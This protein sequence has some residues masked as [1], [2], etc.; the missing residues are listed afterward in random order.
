MKIKFSLCSMVIFSIMASSANALTIIN[1]K[2]N[3][4]VTPTGQVL[5]SL[6]VQYDKN[7]DPI[8]ISKQDFKVDG[9]II[10]A[11]Y[12]SDSD[13]NKTKSGKYITLSVDDKLSKLVFI[14]SKNF[15]VERKSPYVTIY[16]IGSVAAQTNSS[17][18]AENVVTKVDKVVT[19]VADDF[20]PM[21]FHDEKN[22]NTIKYN[23]FIPKHYDPNKKYPLVLFMHDASVLSDQVDTTLMQGTGAL[24]FA[25]P[26]AQI[27]HE[28]FVL[29]PQYNQ[30]IVNDNHDVSN[31]L[32]STINLVNQLSNEYS[33]D[34]TRLYN[35]GQSMGA[36]MSIVMDIKYDDMFAASLIVAGQWDPEVIVP[37][38]NDNLWIIVS[39]GDEKAYPG[40]NAMM[41]KLNSSGAEIARSVWDGH[42]SKQQFTEAYNQLNSQEKRINYVA[43]KKGS[44]VP[45]GVKD[46]G[47]NNHMNTWPIAYQLM[48]VQDWLFKGSEAQWNE[49]VR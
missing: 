45:D 37:L 47:L 40:E 39:Q 21:S 23:L 34:R 12:L 38:T 17:E 49:N 41:D 15:K 26:E 16:Q 32:D 24:T 36:M 13:G 28:A 20:V 1:S 48:D 30:M 35:C 4:K 11:A 9:Q 42:W 19:P 10:S 46:D 43:L 44:V 31:Q 6:T 29:A 18:V 25:T 27:K 33:I 3:T 2:A 7:I 14:S 5:E 22:D 8:S